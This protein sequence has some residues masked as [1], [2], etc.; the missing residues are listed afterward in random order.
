MCLALPFPQT[1]SKP[2]TIYTSE[3][4]KLEQI[5]K[6]EP[7]H[8]TESPIHAFIQAFMTAKPEEKKKP[9]TPAPTV[10]PYYMLYPYYGLLAM[11]P[12]PV[13]PSPPPFFYRFRMLYN[14]FG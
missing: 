7:E 9:E 12:A 13:E 4:I 2:I 5:T 8:K 10:L 14:L 11:R 3:P 6:K 1:T